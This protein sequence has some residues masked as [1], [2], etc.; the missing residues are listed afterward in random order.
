MGMVIFID[1]Y[2]NT[3][4]VGSAMRPMTD[5]KKISREKLA[6]LVDATTA[7]IAGLAIVSTW[8]GY[9]IFLFSSVAES[10]GIDKDGYSM[11]FDALV[12]RFYCLMMVIFV[13]VNVISGR[14]FGE[15]LK[16]ER[17]SHST[18]AVLALDA[19]PMTSGVFS[20]LTY[21]PTAR[22]S[23]FS[24]TIP[25]VASVSYTDLKQPTIWSV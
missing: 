4:I 24:A 11:F 17:R 23:S 9:E 5:G 1:D 22:I 15:M 19:T 21:S 10:I 16:A 7:P 6:F 25:I 20:T 13:F 3:M 14:D 12:Y 18:G 2:A 8:I